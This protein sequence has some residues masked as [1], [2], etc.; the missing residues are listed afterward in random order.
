MSSILKKVNDTIFRLRYGAIEL[1]NARYEKLVNLI[2]G[3]ESEFADVSDEALKSAASRVRSVLAKLKSSGSKSYLRELCNFFA[4]AREAAKRTVA[5]QPYDVQLLASLALAEGKMIEMAT[6]EGK[7]LAA[8]AATCLHAMTGKSSH[9]LT[10]NDYLAERDANWM[11]PVYEFL[12]FTVG[13]VSQGMPTSQRKQ[14]Y[15]QDVTYVTAKEIGFD[16]L[17][18]QLCFSTDEQVQRGFHFAIVDEA[19]SIMVDEARV[20]LVIA[21]EDQKECDLYSQKLYEFAGLVRKMTRDYHYST[22]KGM[23]NVAFTDQGIVWLER[24]LGVSDLFD[25]SNVNMMT[26]L[27]LA[28]QALTLLQRDVDYIVREGRVELIDEFTGRVAEN[29][30][31]PYGLQAAIE[32]KEGLAIQPQGEILKSITLQN[33]LDHYETLSGMTGTA[34]TAAT[35]IHD[36]YDLKTVIVPPNQTCNR[37][38]HP[39]LVFATKQDKLIA[40]VAEIVNQHAT[41]RPILVGTS[42]VEESETLGGMLKQAN[43]HCDI[44]NAKNDLEEATIVAEAGAVSAITI[45]TNMA[46]RGTDIKLG[47]SKAESAQKI[48]ELGGLLVIG[49]NRHES[50]RIDDQLRGRAGRQGDPGET[51]FFVSAEDDLLKRCGIANLDIDLEKFQSGKA[52]ENPVVGRRIAR[53]QKMVEAESLE[54]RRTL[55]LYT[56]CLE[57][58]RKLMQVLRQDLLANNER[59]SLLKI[60]DWELHESLTE[61]FDE[62]L[63]AEAER[64]IAIFHIDDCWAEHLETCSDIRSNIHLASMGGFSAIDEFN[65]RVNASFRNFN[66]RVMEKVVNSFRNASLS[67]GVIDMEEEG[68]KG[69]S[70]TWTYMIN[71]NPTGEVVD[72]LSKVIMRMVLRRK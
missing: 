36:F 15:A 2:L 18:D 24:A 55:R 48:L 38:D 39:D 19:D 71:D 63:V 1:S 45:S 22:T 47:G 12:G 42:S 46:G 5:M 7:T 4:I 23:R 13:H 52:I 3:F 32:A 59:K 11:R 49:T 68:L 41:G 37:V 67:N 9:V 34:Y 44:L 10:F 58:H 64:S 17:R 53:I 54:I 61:R 28:V 62:S 21:G 8:V 26:R 66:D 14:A 60:A 69:P 25:E 40:L 30:R 56:T 16:Y 35:E 6:G 50:R 33:F 65:K 29:R 20:P 43:I 57:Q 70:S 31:W 27:N 51:K 72:R